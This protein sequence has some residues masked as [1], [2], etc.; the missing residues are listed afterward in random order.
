MA[1]DTLYN[2]PLI[3]IEVN[4]LNY[5]FKREREKERKKKL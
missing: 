4:S 5:S 3:F 2:S 1:W